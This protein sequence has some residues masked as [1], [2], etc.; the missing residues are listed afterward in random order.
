MNVDCAGK[1]QRVFRFRLV[2]TGKA[3]VSDRET[4]APDLIWSHQIK[5]IFN[6]IANAQHGSTGMDAES[7]QHPRHRSR[8][9]SASLEGS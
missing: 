8:S 3:R 1:E 2:L 9:I 6:S 7:Y 5:T 4:V